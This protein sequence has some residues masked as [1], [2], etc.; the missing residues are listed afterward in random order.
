MKLSSIILNTHLSEGIR[1]V[2]NRPTLCKGNK[3]IRDSRVFVVDI[4]SLFVTRAIAELAIE[5]LRS[6]AK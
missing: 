2:C 4:S 6:S 1:K 5:Q 3:T